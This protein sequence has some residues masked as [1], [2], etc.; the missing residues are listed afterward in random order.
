MRWYGPRPRAAC[1]GPGS[2]SAVVLGERVGDDLAGRRS[3]P[4]RS[5]RFS[6]QQ[7]G[8]PALDVGEVGHQ[9]VGASRCGR[10]GRWRARLRLVSSSIDGLVPVGQRGDDVVHVGDDRARPRLSRP[11]RRWDRSARVR[12]SAAGSGPRCPDALARRPARRRWRHR[13]RWPGAPGRRRSGTRPRR[14]TAR[15]ARS[16]C[17][18]PGSM[19]PPSSP[20]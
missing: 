3:W 7:L 9:R 13:G 18:S 5:P 2:R 19:A 6:S 16:G 17:V 14:P 8:Q 12:R 1:P 15:T 10:P 20:G 4:S 11:P